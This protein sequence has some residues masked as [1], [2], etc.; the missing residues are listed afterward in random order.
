[1]T[2]TVK[3]LR[4]IADLYESIGEL[5]AAQA[6]RA[7][8]DRIVPGCP[9]GTPAWI[10]DTLA[11]VWYIAVRH[12]DAWRVGQYD[13]ATVVISDDRV[14]SVQVLQSPPQLA[15]NQLVITLDQFLVDTSPDIWRKW[16]GRHPKSSPTSRAI[17]KACSAVADA[18][19]RKQGGDP[20]TR[21]D[22]DQP[23]SPIILCGN[24]CGHDHDAVNGP[25]GCC[26]EH[27]PYLYS[28]PKCHERWEQES[29]PMQ[30]THNE[31]REG[32]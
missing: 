24:T 8:V 31:S 32:C 12:Q 26:A 1:M 21:P 23:V 2:A 17:A 13:N 18:I 20:V 14:A 29:G 5:E 16:A 19:E 6:V 10:A 28:C 15:N 3:V 7:H 30:R 25:T 27:G 4:D 11:D 9:D 22:S